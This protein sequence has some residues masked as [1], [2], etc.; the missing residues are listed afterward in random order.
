MRTVDTDVVVLLVSFMPQF[1]QY[2]AMI[3]VDFGTGKSR[4]SIFINNIASEI[5]ENKCL[6]LLFFF[7]FTGSDTTSSFFGISKTAWWKAWNGSVQSDIS[8]AFQQLSWLPTQ[9]FPHL[10]HCIEN[11]V[12]TLYGDESENIDDMRFN[13]FKHSMRNNLKNSLLHDMYWNN[14]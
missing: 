12:C 2:G 11:F 5:G 13:L 1:Q 10:V 3:I 6:G 9:V 7:A 8:D 4:R 14:I